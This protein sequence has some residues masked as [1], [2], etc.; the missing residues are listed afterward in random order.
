M[1]NVLPWKIAPSPT[2][3]FA[4]GICVIGVLKGIGRSPGRIVNIAP[5]IALI[6]MLDTDTRREGERSM[7][8]ED[9]QAEIEKLEVAV[10]TLLFI[11]AEYIPTHLRDDYGRS[12]DFGCE[13][14]A[15]RE[16]LRQ[17]QTFRASWDK[18]VDCDITQ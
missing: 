12:L 4:H 17:T 1:R 18:K 3:L 16:V 10:K 13:I 8:E 2:G 9:Y 14:K 6:K 5:E 15:V 7:K 11:V